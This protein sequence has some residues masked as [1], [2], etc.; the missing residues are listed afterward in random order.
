MQFTLVYEGELRANQRDPLSH[1]PDRLAQHKQNIRKIFH[2]QLKQL[3]ETNNFLRNHKMP[4]YA[5]NNPHYVRLPTD[6]AVWGNSENNYVSMVE[7]IA[8]YYQHGKYRFVPLVREEISLLCSLDILFLRRDYPGSVIEAGDLDNRI[9][10]LIDCLRMPKGD[11]ELKGNEEPG[12]NEDPFFCLLDDDK[13]VTGLSVRTGT[14]LGPKSSDLDLDRKKV[15]A[16]I[17][18]DLKPYEITMFN[19]SFA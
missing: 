6:Q 2:Q 11:N 5:L 7:V 18:V 12:E 3:W 14:F 17:N 4:P 16:V 8:S 19:L 13:A 10:T 9:K 1:Q 15:H